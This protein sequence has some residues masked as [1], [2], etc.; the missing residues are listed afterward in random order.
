MMATLEKR[1]RKQA[2]EGTTEMVISLKMET[3]ETVEKLGIAKME[4]LACLWLSSLWFATSVVVALPFGLW[5]AHR[6]LQL[7]M[8]HC[9]YF[10]LHQ[11]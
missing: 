5:R 6:W 2:G 11:G 10:L 1:G 3:M 8:S 4:N 7:V 9:Y